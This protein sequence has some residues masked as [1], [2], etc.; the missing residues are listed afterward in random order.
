MKRFSIFTKAWIMSVL[1]VSGLGV[2]QTAQAETA[3]WDGSTARFTKGN[4]TP[5]NP[6]LITTAEEMAYLIVNY[7]HTLVYW[8]RKHFRLTKDLDMKSTQWTFG[9]A[10][11]ENK[12]FRI[13]F[14]GNGHKIS[15]IEISLQDSPKET[16]YGLFPQL[17]GDPEFESVI[18]NLEIENM[19]YVRNT[20]NA[21]GT[22]N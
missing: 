11:S 9:S 7:D 5:E 14:D 17:G 1:T 20:G 13:H 12:T 10:S 16:H 3:V 6:F 19:H 8:N 4:G 22:Y 15:N 2:F 21:N 18:E